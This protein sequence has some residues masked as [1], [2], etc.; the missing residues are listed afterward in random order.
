MSATSAHFTTK[1][2]NMTAK[3]PS[4]L[5]ALLGA[6]RGCTHTCSGGWNW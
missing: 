2:K 6:K 1:L 5:A 3:K 4:L